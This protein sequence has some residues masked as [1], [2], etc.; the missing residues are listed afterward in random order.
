MIESGLSIL[1]SMLHSFKES[2]RRFVVCRAMNLGTFPWMLSSVKEE[3][4]LLRCGMFPV[5]VTEL[6]YRQPFIPIVLLL[7]DED[8]KV[9]FYILIHSFR[10]PIS[11]WMKGGQSILLDAKEVK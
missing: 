1:P 6:G 10:L 3:R 8:A 5:I 7:I 2:I 11:S 4:C 9:L